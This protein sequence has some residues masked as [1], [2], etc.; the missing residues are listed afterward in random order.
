MKPKTASFLLLIAL[1]VLSGCTQVS[2]ENTPADNTGGQLP[3]PSEPPNPEITLPAEPVNADN[4][5]A[6]P[7]EEIPPLPEFPQEL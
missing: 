5:P 4:P 6:V 7:E 1:L 3:V 2:K